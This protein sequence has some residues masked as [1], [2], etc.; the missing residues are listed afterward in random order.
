VA[1]TARIPDQTRALREEL[2]FLSGAAERRIEDAHDRAAAA[3]A[4]DTADRAIRAG[5]R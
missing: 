2:R 3:E 5:C 1:A 4:L